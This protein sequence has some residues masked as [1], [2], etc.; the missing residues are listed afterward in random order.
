MAPADYAA[1]LEE[2]LNMDY[3]PL[4]AELG[5]NARTAWGMHPAA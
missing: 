3:A 2:T 1:V 5:I 4:F